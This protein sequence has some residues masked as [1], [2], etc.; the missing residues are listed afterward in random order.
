MFDKA[1]DMGSEVIGKAK[2]VGSEVFGKIND[3][4]TRGSVS[5][6]LEEQEGVYIKKGSG[7]RID[8]LKKLGEEVDGRKEEEEEEMK[9][10]EVD[11]TF[12]LPPIIALAIGIIYIFLGA[13]MY[14]QW[15]NWSYMEAFYFTFISLSTI[16]FG[17]VIPNHPKFFLAS[18][19]YLLSG[20][21]LIA[22][23]INVV[24]EAVDA[25]IRKASSVLNFRRRTKSMAPISEGGRQLKRRIS[26]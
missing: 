10:Y 5:R 6:E 21:S 13:F 17:D 9:H 7:E 14:K 16:G 2:D 24:M 26:V 3:L 4:T 8:L 20:L 19:I 11:D 25:T 18:F 1:K 23:I 22:M 12:N 15:E